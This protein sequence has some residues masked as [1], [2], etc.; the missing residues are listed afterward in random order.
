VTKAEQVFFA[1][2]GRI[3]E[4]CGER[5]STTGRK[6]MPWTGQL[7]KGEYCDECTKTW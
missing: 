1:M 3:C 4:R 7:S 2:R 5:S 6:L